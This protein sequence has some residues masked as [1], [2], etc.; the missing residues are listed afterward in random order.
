MHLLVPCDLTAWRLEYRVGLLSPREVGSERIRWILLRPAQSQC[1]LASGAVALESVQD[2][3][4]I[5][6]WLRRVDRPLLIGTQPV[7]ATDGL[8]KDKFPSTWRQAV[9]S[10]DLDE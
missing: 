8:T 7:V 4:L 10:I 1:Q 5:C 6:G 3:E 2:G 9:Q